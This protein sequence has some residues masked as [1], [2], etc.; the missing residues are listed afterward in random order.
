V[1][2]AV[3]DV[4]RFFSAPVHQRRHISA[5]TPEASAASCSRR[6]ATR[7]RR[8]GSMQD[9]SERG[10]DDIS[11]FEP[12]IELLEEFKVSVEAPDWQGLEELFPR[13]R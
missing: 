13:R 4:V 7:L 11:L 6:D 10:D 1:T 9:V 3:G 12:L 2:A 8:Y 5:G